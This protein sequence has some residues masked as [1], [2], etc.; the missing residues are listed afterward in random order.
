ME[1]KLLQNSSVQIKDHNGNV[2]AEI[3]EDGTITGLGANIYA[4]TGD[5][6]S[7]P[8]SLLEKLKIGDMI[9]Y[10]EQDSEDYYH[11]D[12]YTVFSTETYESGNRSV[13]MKKYN[14][15]D[16]EAYVVGYTYSAESE[17][18]ELIEE[19]NVKVGNVIRVN[20]VSA[21]SNGELTL[22]CPMIYEVSEISHVPS[23]ILEQVKIGDIIKVDTSMHIVWNID[24]NNNVRTGVG[25]LVNSFDE[26]A[27]YWYSYRK[28][29]NTWNYQSDTYYPMG[30]VSVN[31][32]GYS[33]G[34]GDIELP[35]S[36]NK[37]EFDEYDEL[38]DD[39]IFSESSIGD[40]FVRNTSVG[41]KVYKYAD[42][43]YIQSPS[44]NYIY[45][46]E[47]DDEVV[48]FIHDTSYE[49]WQYN[50][51]RK[52]KAL[53][54]DAYG[55]DFET[56][57]VSLIE[58]LEVGDLVKCDT[59]IGKVT[60]KTFANLF[61]VVV[62]NSE[63]ITT[64]TYKYTQGSWRLYNERTCGLP[65]VHDAD[66]EPNSSITEAIDFS[67][68]K[69]GD[70][71]VNA[72]D[73]DY[74]VVT[75]NDGENIEILIY[76]SA[77]D[78]PVLSYT[79]DNADNRWEY[80][81]QSMTPRAT[82]HHIKVTD[83]GSGD[84]LE[85]IFVDNHASHYTNANQINWGKIIS[86]KF[87]TDLSDAGSLEVGTRLVNVSPNT[88]EISIIGY[89]LIN[90]VMHEQTYNCFTNQFTLISDDYTIL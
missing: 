51:Y 53:D 83:A 47:A 41:Q 80:D 89:Q 4:Y 18:W 81:G 23:I 67:K 90:N 35:C 88:N 8:P 1:I 31:G 15:D 26:G 6:L 22:P 45:T 43:K 56:M 33:I 84:T 14:P 29:N 36:M 2:I 73:F 85:M 11:Y 39:S 9:Y 38:Y 64:Y 17:E 10:H 52:I 21:D 60:Q 48:V 78:M 3:N 13:Y 86:F 27:F 63:Y 25:L 66:G 82:E 42:F 72:D 32:Y 87:A 28:T 55:L 16:M 57:S 40:F 19:Y 69:V 24:V 49:N 54:L 68:L 74:G 75:H 5:V 62:M 34:N 30:A 65:R 61:E 20:D 79:F 7:L 46:L 12:L 58:T 59:D 37:N 77:G 50:V 44:E 76:Y 70:V 71:I